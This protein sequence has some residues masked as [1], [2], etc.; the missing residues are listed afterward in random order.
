MATMPKALI[1]GTTGLLGPYVT[2]IFSKEYE[3]IKV[4]S[5]GKDGGIK[6]DFTNPEI[7]RKTIELYS[8]DLILNLAAYTDV[9]GC[10]NN[11][12]KA[13]EMN[14]KMVANIVDACGGSNIR[15]IQISTDQVYANTSGLHKEGTENPVNEYGRSKLNGEK[16]ALKRDSSLVLRVNMF[17]TS[18]TQGR[19]SLSDFFIDSFKNQSPVTLFDDVFFSPLNLDTLAEII[20]KCA[21]SK[22]SGTYNLG[23]REGMSKKDFALK[24]AEHF[25]LSTNNATYGKS[26]STA[27]RAIR[28]LDLRM[29]VTKIESSLGITIPTLEE[30]IKKLQPNH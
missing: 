19:K 4:S 10:E 7:A 26:V 23:S 9:D 24:I 21:N 13:D 6:A 8:P 18:K 2:E 1:V 15:L 11:P 22:L 12:A 20:L 3:V 25:N 16:E 30:E 5:S 14:R 28:P 27:G 17:G 29:D